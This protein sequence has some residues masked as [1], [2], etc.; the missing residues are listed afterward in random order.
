M[1]FVILVVII[2]L[3]KGTWKQWLVPFAQDGD[4]LIE[5]IRGLEFLAA[6]H[7]ERRDARRADQSHPSSNN[8]QVQL[9]EPEMRDGTGGFP[10]L[11]PVALS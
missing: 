8:T 11:P 5:K 6:R 2:K 9:N 7:N 1:V 3:V 4:K 10:M